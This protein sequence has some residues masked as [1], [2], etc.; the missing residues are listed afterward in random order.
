[1]TDALAFTGMVQFL[2]ALA[3]LGKAI[4]GIHDGEII[5]AKVIK[6][7]GYVLSAQANAV[8]A[9][10]ETSSRCWKVNANLKQS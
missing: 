5:K 3:Q 4:V 9:Q 8:A 2:T 7:N 10:A 1:M 6:L